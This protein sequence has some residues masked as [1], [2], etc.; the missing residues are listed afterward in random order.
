MSRKTSVSHDQRWCPAA[1]T[2]QS[3]TPRSETRA[4]RRKPRRAARPVAALAAS[5]AA[6]AAGDQLGE[7]PA[8]DAVV[9]PGGAGSVTGAAAGALVGIGGVGGSLV[10]SLGAA[11]AGVAPIGS[12]ADDR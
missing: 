3:P 4:D 12:A 6:G 10:T 5:G 8:V 1:S 11:A 2:G 7:C 9:P